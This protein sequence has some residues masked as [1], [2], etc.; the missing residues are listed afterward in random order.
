MDGV[1]PTAIKQQLVNDG[2]QRQPTG[3]VD[4]PVWVDTSS[5]AVSGQGMGWWP[6]TAGKVAPL[7]SPVAR[8]RG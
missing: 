7:A 8:T 5:M 1:W 2:S 6:I 4:R 3:V